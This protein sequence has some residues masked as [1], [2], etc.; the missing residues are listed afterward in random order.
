MARQ[1]GLTTGT[2]RG[3][4]GYDV[5]SPFMSGLKENLSSI[6]PLALN[7][8]ALKMDEEKAQ[9]ILGVRKEELARQ[10]EKTKQENLINQLKIALPIAYETKSQEMMSQLDPTFKAAT[11]T[12]LP[13]TEVTTPGRIDRASAED[14]L[15]A[16]APQTTK[17]YVIPQ[18]DLEKKLEILSATSGYKQDLQDKMN[19]ARWE[20]MKENNSD[21]RMA[22]MAR[23]ASGGGAQESWHDSG[24]TD[25]EGYPVLVSNRGNMK[26]GT[27]LAGS[28][29]TKEKVADLEKLNASIVLNNDN[30]QVVAPM[31][32][33]FNKTAT[34]AS[35]SFWEGEKGGVVKI[36]YGVDSK[37]NPITNADIQ[38]EAKRS[39]KSFGDVVGQLQ[40]RGM[41]Q[42]VEMPK[43]AKK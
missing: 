28:K 31:A 24:R 36:A 39:G 4:P 41:A 26:R 37:G 21:K 30:W 15:T 35:W 5:T 23:I 27:M 42:Y 9:A 13:T 40:K 34:D 7:A 38:A 3:T 11:G 2:E 16:I 6:V 29:P 19:Q 22:M 43:P 8:T 17:Q 14:E 32:E 1:F 18:T 25:E 20:L 33:N 10:V 12:S